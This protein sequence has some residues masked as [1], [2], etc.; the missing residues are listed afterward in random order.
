MSSGKRII[1]LGVG[2]RLMGDDGFGPRVIDLLESTDLA[3]D[4]EFRDAGTARAK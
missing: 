2:N 4:V 1:V 3:D